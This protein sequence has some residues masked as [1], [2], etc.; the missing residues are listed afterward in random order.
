MRSSALELVPGRSQAASRKTDANRQ[1]GRRMVVVAQGGVALPFYF[2]R[3]EK[4]VIE[5]RTY[6]GGQT[7]MTQCRRSMARTTPHQNATNA[8]AKASDGSVGPNNGVIQSA[9]PLR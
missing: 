4:D 7:L 6:G 3:V 1:T 2:K 5:R 9:K 8:S